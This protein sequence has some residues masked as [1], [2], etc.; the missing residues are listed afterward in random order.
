[1]AE[2]F[3]GMSTDNVFI[4]LMKRSAIAFLLCRHRR[5]QTF[6]LVLEKTVNL[7]NST[8]ESHDLEFVVRNVHDQVLAHNGQTDEAE[9]STGS[10]PRR[11]ADID[12]GKTGAIVSSWLSSTLFN[13]A[14]RIVCSNYPGGTR[15]EYIVVVAEE[16]H[17]FGCHLE[18]GQA[19]LGRKREATYTA[20]PVILAF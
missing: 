2:L 7:C 20:C 6:C 12:A 14:N 17:F 15:W 3:H 19:E 8:V 18:A 9:I 1:M 13:S 4:A 10:D 11:S 16:A 5:R